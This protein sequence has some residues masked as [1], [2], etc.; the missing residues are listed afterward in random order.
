MANKKSSGVLKWIIL[1]LVLG[2]G[3]YFG[4]NYYSKRAKEGPVEFKTAPVAKGDITQSVTANGALN[5]VRTVTVGSQIS[6]IITELKVDFNSKVK[7]GDVLA[8]IDPATYERA[9]A[10]ADADLSNAQ[11]GLELA[12]FND[13]RAKQLYAEKLISET[14]F[15][16]TAVALLQA[17]ANVK[18]YY[19]LLDKIAVADKARAEAEAAAAAAAKKG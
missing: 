6:G 17:E 15:Q 5:P 16:Q 13:K 14:E 3:G 19:D 8:K 18:Y 9:Q 7:Q 1:L 11:A 12:K 2:G 4:W 10:R